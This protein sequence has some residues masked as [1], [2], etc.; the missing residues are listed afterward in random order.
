[1]ASFIQLVAKDLITKYQYN[2]K[3]LTVVFPN[4]RA[5]LFL[6]D[7]LSELVEKPTWM[8]EIFTFHEFIEQQTGIKKAENIT[9]TINC[10]K[11]TCK[12][13]E[14]TKNSKISIS[15]EICYWKTSTILI[16]I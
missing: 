1:M 14:Q 9:L 5:G 11:P 7:A 4:K 15:G 10:I 6:A 8:P 16:N 13:R 12:L 3:D 2:L